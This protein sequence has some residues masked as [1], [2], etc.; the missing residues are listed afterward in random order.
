MPNYPIPPWLDPS[1]AQGYGALAQHASSIAL[2]NQMQRDRLSQQAQEFAVDTQQRSQEIAAANAAKQEQLNY[3][4]QLEQQK[5]QVDQAYKQQQIALD[6]QSQQL[7]EKQFAAKTQDAAAKFT[8]NQNFQK[9]ILP[10][11]QGGEG[12]NAIQ[13]ALKY[14]SPHMTGT[15]VG[16]LAALP[17]DFKPGNTFAIPNASSESL[18]QVAPNRWEKYATIPQTVTNVPAAIPV[19]DA[20]GKTIGNVIQIPGEKPRYENLSS[21]GDD[22]DEM[23]KKRLDAKSG[24]KASTA[25]D[26]KKDEARKAVGGYKIGIVYRGGLKYLG[27]DPNDE[28][29]WEK[30]K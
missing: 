29:S 4:H 18:V 12:L 21:K 5:M 17:G 30:V 26:T 19:P 6:Q 1:A 14:M 20:S 7:A 22:L 3:E 27:G 25:V 15:E 9:A 16:R 11:E 13:A 28:S 23:I 8:A 24:G 10:K 2:D